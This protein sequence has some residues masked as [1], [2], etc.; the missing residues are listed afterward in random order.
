MPL[1]ASRPARKSSVGDAQADREL[2]GS[3][4]IFLRDDDAAH[5]VAA[6]GADDMR[7]HHRA[8]LGARIE[9]A[10]NLEM[11]RPTLAGA[12]IGAFSLWNSHLI[13]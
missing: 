1:M 7:W 8:A 2:G 4:F 11:V 3:L 12:G 9:L 10:C 13:T 5:V 6:I